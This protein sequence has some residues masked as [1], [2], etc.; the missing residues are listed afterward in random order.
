MRRHLFRMLGLLILF[1]LS[2]SACGGESEERGDLSQPCFENQACITPYVCEDGICVEEEE[3]EQ[4]GQG[5]LGQACYGN[6]TCNTPYVCEEDICV[7]PD[8]VDEGGLGQPCFADQTCDTPYL[9]ED[10]VCVQPGGL[11]QGDIGQPCYADQTCDGSYVCEV[12]VCVEPAQPTGGLGE[13][14]RMD[15][16]CDAPLVCDGGSCIEDAPQ[17]PNCGDRP[18]PAH[19]NRATSCIW[20]F[21]GPNTSIDCTLWESF[22]N[23]AFPFPSI[24]RQFYQRP[25]E[26]LALEFNTGDY[27]GS[28]HGY[29]ESAEP[30]YGAPGTFQSGQIL[31]TVSRCPGDFHREAIISESEPTCYVRGGAM[32]QIHFSPLGYPDPHSI[33]CKLEPNTTYFLNILFTDSPAG[34]APN[35]L[36]WACTGAGPGL[37]ENCGRLL[38]LNSSN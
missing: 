26:Y 15:G 13:P 33:L 9:C 7:A 25:G 34:T 38:L 14:C 5:G 35:D 4:E 30:Q 1:A 27:T 11:D 23:R 22:F 28:V 21:T 24:T 16:S 8:E 31:Y 19:L 29:I 12:D 2:G 17:G 36:N 6:Q 20:D 10:A 18:P 37:G 32:S 3:Q